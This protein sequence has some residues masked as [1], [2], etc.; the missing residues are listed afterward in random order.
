MIL[1]RGTAHSDKAIVAEYHHFLEQSDDVETRTIL[2][3][4]KEA[5]GVMKRRI[6]KPIAQWREGDIFSLYTDRTKTVRYGYSA[7]VAF[8]IFRGY[9]RPTLQFC[10]RFPLGFTRYHRQ[11]L[12]PIRQKLEETQQKLGYFK[13]RV[14][15]ELNLLIILLAIVHKPLSALTR[16]D[17][18]AFRDDYQKWYRAQGR[19]SHASDPRLTRLE[20]FLVHWGA[21][22]LR[23]VVYRHEEHFARLQSGPI[24]DAIVSFLQWGEAKYQPS[25]LRS[26]QAGLL[27]FFLWF[28]A[29]A[30]FRNRLDG[31]TRPL[32]LAY[33]RHLKA[34]REQ[35]KYSIVHSND[36]YRSVRL[37]YEFVIR[38]G[39]KTSPPRNPFA[40]GDMPWAPDPVPRYLTD[41]E[42]RKILD[43]CEQGASLKERT[44]VITL[45]HT[46]IRAAELAALKISDI[47]QVQGK[48]KLHIHEGK[49]LKDRLIPL[50]PLCL[51]MLQ[52]WQ[53]AGWEQANDHLF[54]RYGRRWQSSNV[55]AIIR[56]L[57]L[58]LGVENLT[59]H[60]FRHT[61]AVALLNYG[62]R[63]S[64]LQKV[65]G[66][67]TLS[68][69][70]EYARILD[71]T[72]EQAFNSAVE[73]MQAGPVSW[74]PSFFATEDYSLFAEGD[75]VSWIRLPHG[76]CRRNPKLHCES[77]VKCLLCDRFVASV[78][79]LPRFQEMHGRFAALGLQVKADVVA[80]Q[81][82][83]LE[84]G[85]RDGFIPVNEIFIN[86][87]RPSA[88]TSSI[89]QT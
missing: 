54:T 23:K 16:P 28:Q 38:E 8:L 77:D 21:I 51:E 84:A 80:A 27:N 39:L 4:L 70:L 37:F 32:A 3:R 86:G 45:F 50:T 20:F 33:G 48:W 89:A 18:D 10:K 88:H 6:G 68:M 64:A 24:R 71:Q 63:E 34:L 15:S 56:E 79:D 72:V 44:L 2:D 59:P 46:G 12:Q 58:K 78:T 43:H 82:R 36:M 65:M 76:Y 83:R 42:I 9:C 75:A 22:A 81:I 60:R 53:A 30:P 61:F 25:T 67:A 19:K 14:G 62:M 47:V 52:R 7:F 17:F 40:L 41:H 26:R 57:G 74:V 55:C 73:Q 13:S 1:G 35:G 29:Q 31:V 5:P 85:T 11:A 49:G 69:T 66:H 87:D